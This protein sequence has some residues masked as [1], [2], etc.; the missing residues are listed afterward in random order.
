MPRITNSLALVQFPQ[1]HTR[2]AIASEGLH[3]VIVER[4]LRHRGHRELDAHVAAAA[5]KQTGR[6]WPL[7]QGGNAAQ[8]DAVIA[9]AM[10]AERAQHEEGPARLLGWL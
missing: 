1:S 6:G 3:R 8:I 10:A 2:T 9:L 5:A 7:V 4:T